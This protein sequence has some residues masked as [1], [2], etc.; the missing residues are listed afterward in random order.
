[1]EKLAINHYLHKLELNIQQVKCTT[2]GFIVSIEK[3]KRS[4]GMRGL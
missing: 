2:P 3:I 4:K 1:V